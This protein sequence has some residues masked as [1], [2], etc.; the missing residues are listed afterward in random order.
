MMR[1]R[2]RAES[3]MRAADRG[4]SVSNPHLSRRKYRG[5]NGERAP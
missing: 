3:R 2:N 5:I 1:Q 4:D